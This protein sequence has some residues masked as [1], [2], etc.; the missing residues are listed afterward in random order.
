[1][2]IEG[3]NYPLQPKSEVFCSVNGLSSTEGYPQ[4]CDILIQLYLLH[5]QAT[6]WLV[7][8]LLIL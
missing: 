6:Q 1:M 2:P 8:T 7:I 4:E 3:L 5:L